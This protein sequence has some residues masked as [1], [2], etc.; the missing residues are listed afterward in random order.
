MA[1]RMAQPW[2]HPKTGVLWFRRAVPKDLRNLVGRREELASLDTKDAAEAR[3][4]YARVSAEV[5]VRWANLRA[6]VRTLTERDA[7]KLA[8]VVHDVWLRWHS[9]EPT[10][11]VRWQTALYDDL[12]TRA[13]EE[14]HGVP[15][16]TICID[17]LMLSGMRR[18]CREQ[19]DNILAH[20]GLK[21]DEDSHHKLA[22]A[23]GAAF[24]RSSLTLGRAAAGEIIL[25]PPP[26]EPATVPE[27]QTL[28]PA[29]A[30]VTLLPTRGSGA[31]CKGLTL[32]GLVDAWWQEAKAAGRK[33][34]TYESY[35]N[36]VRSLVAFLKHDDAARVTA[37]NVVAFKDHRLTTLSRRTGKVPSA[38]TVKDIDLS[39]LNSLFGWAVANRRLPGN[40][41]S[42]ITVKGAKARRLR[43]KGFTD[44]EARAI[45]I[46]ALAH[47]PGREHPRMAAAKR[48]VP[49][50]CAFT[51]ARVGEIG[52]LRR[53]DVRREGEL[54]VIHITPDAG[55]VKT[56]EARDVVLHPQLVDLGFSAFVQASADGPLF[57][58]P[59]KA[60][61]VLGP[62]QALK[63]RL[64]EF[65][66]ALVPEPNVAPTH[67]WRHR[68]KT[69]GLDAGVESRILD[70]I[71]GH[72]PRSISERYGEVSLKVRAAAICKLPSFDLDTGGSPR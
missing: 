64:A 63:N 37:E 71:Q 70:A 3:V 43:S 54:W 4:R 17:D 14:L 11:Q 21:V 42:G 32:T 26:D 65:S 55:T 27:A 5:E 36:T 53:E 40:P 20:H 69:V 23:V 25:D 15:V 13:V 47:V 18:L 24:Q 10:Y 22:R 62:L 59:G 19:A 34:S 49:W 46:A 68:F 60:G 33:P 56:D 58:M 50:L 30:R 61:D 45:L 29:M 12:W 57:L 7:H 2:P 1:L 39:A 8:T 52:Q 41:A 9:E 48:W 31:F 44:E 35:R 16:K 51:G 67:G 72:A 28:A 6:G 38:R 66:R